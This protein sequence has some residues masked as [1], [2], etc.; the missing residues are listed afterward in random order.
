[1]YTYNIKGVCS[2][3]ENGIIFSNG[4]IYSLI[5][6]IQMHAYLLVVGGFQYMMLT[7]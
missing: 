4:A 1:M 3:S 7:N 2:F 5:F 6:R